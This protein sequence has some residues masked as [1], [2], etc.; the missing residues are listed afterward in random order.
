MRG[1]DVAAI[2]VAMTTLLPEQLDGF[3]IEMTASLPFPVDFTGT[4]A[5]D[6]RTLLT[7]VFGAS[8]ETA[9]LF[10]A[11]EACVAI[12]VLLPV[13]MVGATTLALEEVLLP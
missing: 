11:N 5:G 8:V 13:A 1:D 9:A 4:T 3:V 6:A 10:L 7:L 2:G 12:T